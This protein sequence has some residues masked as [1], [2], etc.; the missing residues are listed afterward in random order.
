MNQEKE[1]KK[2]LS[3]LR[4]ERGVTAEEQSDRCNFSGFEDGQNEAQAK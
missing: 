4:S 1:S 3:Q 2:H